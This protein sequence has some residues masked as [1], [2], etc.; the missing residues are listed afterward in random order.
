MTSLQE[1]EERE[2][3]R[4]IRLA[5][6]IPPRG[7]RQ[8]KASEALDL[9]RVREGRGRNNGAMSE[10]RFFDFFFL[11]LRVPSRHCKTLRLFLVLHTSRET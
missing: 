8:Q 2:K 3:R 5:P 7:R 10:K 11:F 1:E 9:E 4:S 6:F